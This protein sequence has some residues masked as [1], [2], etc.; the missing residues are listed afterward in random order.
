MITRYIIIITISLL[1]FTHAQSQAEMNDQ[2]Q[3]DFEATDA[4]LNAL[5][6]Q[7]LK[8]GDAKSD[9]KLRAAQRVWLDFVE[10]HMAYIFPLEKGENP[11]V[12]GSVSENELFLNLL[13]V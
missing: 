6:Q 8:D 9:A 10:L 4:R 2:A 5:Y 7:L 3:K 1:S 13:S 11:R 12:S